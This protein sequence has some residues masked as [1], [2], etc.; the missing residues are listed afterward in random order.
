MLGQ[1]IVQ[2][3]SGFTV[4]PLFTGMVTGSPEIVTS[5]QDQQLNVST[6]NLLISSVTTIITVLGV[7]Y[8][9]NRN[10]ALIKAKNDE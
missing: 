3:V 7:A 10:Q 1:K 5:I 9:Q 2:F 4:A 6:V 8:I